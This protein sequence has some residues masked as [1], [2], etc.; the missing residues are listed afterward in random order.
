MKNLF[1]LLPILLLSNSY[2]KEVDCEKNKV[3][4]RIIEVSP[5][6]DKNF[7]MQLSNYIHKYSKQFG[8]DPMISVA[9]A[10]QESSF[11]NIDKQGSILLSNGRV[12]RGHT[13]LGVFQIHINTIENLKKEANWNIDYFK[14]RND[15][16]YQTYWHIRILKRKIETCEKMKDKLNIENGNEWSCY[17]SYTYK[18][19][20]KY[21][22]DVNRYLVNERVDF[23]EY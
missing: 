22:N 10:M 4:C 19:R 18:H 11:R 17:H 2:A 13:D 7:A 21:V 1:Y 8:T 5:S 20:I 12:V 14:L 23:T 3:Y 15:V 16:E 6:T 9:I